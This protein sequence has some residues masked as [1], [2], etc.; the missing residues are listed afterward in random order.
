[1]FV[2][3][4]FLTR[5][6]NASVLSFLFETWTTEV[7]I[8]ARV[9]LVLPLTIGLHLLTTTSDRIAVFH[10]FARCL[11]HVSPADLCYGPTGHLMQ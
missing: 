11:P 6:S 8:M 10:A 5:Y 9:G 4:L 7:V 1:M 3:L 2:V